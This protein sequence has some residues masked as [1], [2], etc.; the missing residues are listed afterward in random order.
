MGSAHPWP[1][2]CLSLIH[3]TLLS[4]LNPFFIFRCFADLPPL[5]A[6][7][8]LF[9]SLLWSVAFLPPLHSSAGYTTHIAL[10]P[11]ILLVLPLSHTHTHKH[12]HQLTDNHLT[13]S[14]RLPHS[15]LELCPAGCSLSLP[16]LPCVVM[17]ENMSRRS[18]TLLSLSLTSLALALSVLA[19]CTSYWCEG[20][21]KVV[22]PPCLSPVK[23]KKCGQNNS[24][25]YTTGKT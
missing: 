16:P 7:F 12:Q 14:I 25:P 13:H 4:L 1:S 23:M 9:N 6:S 10:N 2:I 11:S 5:T 22:K 18:R 17:L 21:H 3:L 19:F 24:L 15:I 8:F 20:T